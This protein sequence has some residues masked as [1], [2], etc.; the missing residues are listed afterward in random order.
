MR[1]SSNR[2]R[3]GFTLVELLVVVAIITVL[4]GLLLPAVQKAREAA[5]SAQCKSNLHQL[6]VALHT[7]ASA[8]N[9]ML[10]PGLLGDPTVLG[11][12]FWFGTIPAGAKVVD[13]TGGTLTKYFE[14]NN[15][16]IQCPSLDL[17]SISLAYDGKTG[18]YGYNYQYLSPPT[19]GAGGT[20]TVP[21]Q[22]KLTSIKSTSNTIAF[23][24]ALSVDSF[25]LG[26]ATN[27]V[28]VET[29]LLEP[30]LQTYPSSHF[31]HIGDTANVLFLDGHVEGRKAVVNP[32]PSWEATASVELRVKHQIYDL[33]VDDSIYDRD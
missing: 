1:S 4:I 22:V 14:D 16:L 31:R 7:Y 33:Y 10:P 15:Q 26:T 28:L 23:S 3:P 20:V 13:T 19:W 17:L 32:P 12:T 11:R 6:G 9:N 2:S 24:D 25:S 30:T 29:P 8:N 27:P 21:H 18:G 5:A